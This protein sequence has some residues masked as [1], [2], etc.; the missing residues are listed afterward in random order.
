MK[1]LFLH[2][3]SDLYGASKILIA[4]TGL[5]K[6]QGH[7]VTVVLSEPGPLITKLTDAGITV[8][9]LPLGVLRRKYI[10]PWGIL[11]RL[12]VS[13]KA[14]FL[15]KKLCSDQQIELIYS[16]TTGVIICG[17]VSQA[18][19]IRHIWHVHEIIASPNLFFRLLRWILNR[20][21][22]EILVVSEAVKNHWRKKVAVEKIKVLYNGVD[23]ELFEDN[24]STFRKELGIADNAVVMGMMGRVHFWKGQDYFLKIAGRLYQ[25]FPN[26]Q[27]VLVGDPFPGYE[28]LYQDMDAIIQ[29]FQMAHNVHIVGYRED[30]SN[31][32]HAFDI[33]VLPSQ[34]PD[35]APAVVTEAMSAGIAVVV[36]EQGGAVEMIVNQESGLL[37]PLHDAEKAAAIISSLVTDAA[38]RNQL[39]KQAKDRI[40]QHFSRSVFNKAIIQMIEKQ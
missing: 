22:N 24:T 20:N 32:F 35:P 7:E 21:G 3:S 40:I 19:G 15:L 5:C 38:L 1:I 16:N 25:S 9:Q 10:N 26:L 36:T 34:L 2:S 11:N 23:Y 31:I 17:F 30:I 18:L 14:Y 12:I 39:G 8:V 4:V 27:F 37:I 6:K 29:Q 28:Y 13:F 33:F